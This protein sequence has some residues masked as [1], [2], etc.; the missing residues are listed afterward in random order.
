MDLV[1]Y[2]RKSLAVPVSEG[3]KDLVLF[4]VG[5]EATVTHLG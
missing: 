3:T 1:Y 5:L 4:L 2:S